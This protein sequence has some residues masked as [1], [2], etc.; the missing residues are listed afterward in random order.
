M[1][2]PKRDLRLFMFHEFKFE[3]NVSEPKLLSVSTEHGERYPYV[4]GQYEGGFKN[5]VME[6]TALKM[7]EVK[8]DQTVLT[9]NNYK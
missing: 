5:L 1:N 9:M 6:M 8:D 4:I 7:N 3:H 2:M